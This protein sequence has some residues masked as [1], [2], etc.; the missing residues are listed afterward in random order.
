MGWENDSVPLILASSPPTE[1]DNEIPE[2]LVV[3]PGAAEALADV[4]DEVED[5]A[6]AARCT[7]EF[8]SSSSGIFAQ[9]ST[10]DVA[11]TF[12]TEMVGMDG[13]AVAMALVE[14]GEVVVA[15]ILLVACADRKKVDVFSVS[16]GDVDWD[17]DK[18]PEAFS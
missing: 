6:T 1:A 5:A 3:G 11:V 18:D 10:R 17:S 14:E 8:Q 7:A 2:L 4:E 9:D 12:V 16:L 15:L 13:G